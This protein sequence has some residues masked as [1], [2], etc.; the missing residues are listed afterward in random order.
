MALVLAACSP[1]EEPA[2]VDSSSGETCGLVVAVVTES[3]VVKGDGISRS[4]YPETRAEELTGFPAENKIDKFDLY[5]I[6]PDGNV[7]PLVPMRLATDDG[8]ISFLVK[9]NLGDDYVRKTP[10]GN[11]YLSGRIVAIAN[12]PG[13]TPFSP[14]DIPEFNLGDI[15]RKGV[16]PMWGVTAISNLEVFPN[17][18]IKAGKISML[19]SIPKLSFQLS[20]ELRDQY[21]IVSVSSP[22][23][24]F[25][26]SGFC[27][28]EGCRGAMSTSALGVESCFNPAGAATGNFFL[29]AGVGS[30]NVAIYLAE[31]ECQTDASG[32]PTYFDLVISRIG[33]DDSSIAGRVYLC[34]YENGSPAFSSRLNNLVRNH[35][36]QYIISLAGLEFKISFTEWIPGGN[37]HIELE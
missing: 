8:S 20:P 36:Y 15:P 5:I 2:S 11:Y 17:K 25:E 13:A 22:D 32:L 27:Q 12:Y 7:Y 30:A 14:L 9:M 19:R 1:S 4:S 3:T 26:E 21:R 23:T 31:R 6:S 10:E 18:T 35:D 33:V 37:V 16:I 24:G 28:P 29:S 34:D